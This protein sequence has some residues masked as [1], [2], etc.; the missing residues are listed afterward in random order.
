M[1]AAEHEATVAML[2]EPLGEL[3]TAVTSLFGRIR[4]ARRCKVINDAQRWYVERL[5]SDGVNCP[6]IYRC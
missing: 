2:N 4:P 6:V 3:E 1:M 5:A